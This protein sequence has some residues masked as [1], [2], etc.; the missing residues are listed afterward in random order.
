MLSPQS[1]RMS[2]NDL[3]VFGLDKRVALADEASS[4][5]AAADD[6]VAAG[7]LGKVCGVCVAL[8]C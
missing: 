2:P 5:N 7:W 4:G 3:G 1:S 8:F 6:I